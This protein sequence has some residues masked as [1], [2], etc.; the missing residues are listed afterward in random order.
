MQNSSANSIAKFSLPSLINYTK[1]INIGKIS[2]KSLFNQYKR[3]YL[4][5]DS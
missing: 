4:N 5:N 3:Y 2:Q 1:K